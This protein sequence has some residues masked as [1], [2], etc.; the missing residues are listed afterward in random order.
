MVRFSMLAPLI[1]LVAGAPLHAREAN[2]FYYMV[3]FS[4][5][6]PSNDPR[7]THSFA[8][9]V[10]A[11]GT[12]DSAE[13]YRTEVHTI[14]WMPRSLNIRILRRRL[15]PGVNLDLQSSL[16][17][18]ESRNCRVLMWGP[19]EIDQELYDRAIQ[20]EARLRSGR[21]LYKAL[22]RRFRPGIASNCIHAVSD[23]DVDNG[24]LDT[25]HGRG[26]AASRQ[27]A[28]HLNGWIIDRGQTH[29]WVANRLF[30][31]DPAA[32]RWDLPQQSLL[33]SQSKRQAD[34]SYNTSR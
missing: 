24:L 4:A 13:D 5:Q 11:T 17:W 27:V 22:D 10:K 19:Y 21:V 12:G 26:H 33:A 2:E 30:L 18:A 25:G 3:M 20:Q 28:Q 8:T 23:L 32:D 15:E 34:P 31:T 7:L 6:T 1:L 16:R 29:S 9:F 14:S